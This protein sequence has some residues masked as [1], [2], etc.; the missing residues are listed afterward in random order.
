M[1]PAIDFRHGVFLSNISNHRSIAFNSLK[2][3]QQNSWFQPGYRTVYKKRRCSVVLYSTPVRKLVGQEAE[4]SLVEKWIPNFPKQELFRKVVMVRFD[5]MILLQGMKEHQ[6][7]PANSF[8]TIKYLYEADAKVVLMSSWNENMSSRFTSESCPS[9]ESVAVFLSSMLELKVVLVNFVPGCVQLDK[10]ECKTPN[11]LLLENLSCF[12]GERANCSKFAK[13]LASG[14]DIIV[15]DAFSESHKVLASTVGVASFCYTCMAGFYFEEGLY[16]LKKIIKTSES[17][18]LAIVGGGNLVE[19]AAALKFLASTCDGLIFVGSMAFQILHVLGVPVPVKFVDLGALKAAVSIVEFAKSRN[20][21]LVLPKDVRCIKY[22][23]PEQMEIF[24][25]HSIPEGWQPVDIGPRSLEEMISFLLRCKYFQKVTWI[26]PLRFSSPKQDE[27]G[28]FKLAEAL[29]TLSGC[30]VTFVGQT[31]FEELMGKS[32]SFPNVN[33]LKSSA[34]VWKVLNGRKLPGLMALDRVYPF[35]VD[36]NV[37]YGDP[38]RPLV[39]DVGSG[40]GLFLFGMASRRKEM[41]FLGLEMNTKLVDRCLNDVHRLGIQNVHFISTNATSTF[42]SIVS[43]YTGEL[44]LVSIQCPNPDFNK[45]ENRWRMLQMSLVKAIAD[46]LML[47]GKSGL[48]KNLVGLAQ[49]KEYPKI[50]Q[51]KS[52]QKKDPNKNMGNNPR[53]VLDPKVG[54]RPNTYEHLEA[55]D[56][57]QICNSIGFRPRV[58]RSMHLFTT[59]GTF[60]IR[61]MAIKNATMQ[62]LHL[63]HLEFEAVA[64][65][66][67]DLTASWRKTHGGGGSFPVVV[68]TKSIHVYKL[69]DVLR[70]LTEVREA[71]QVTFSSL[72]SEIETMFFTSYELDGVDGVRFN[73]NVLVPSLDTHIHTNQHSPEL[74]FINA[75]GVNFSPEGSFEVSNRIPQ[76]A[77]HGS[78]VVFVGTI[79]IEFHEIG[80]SVFL[81]S[82]IEAVAVRMKNEFIE[83]GDGKLVVAEHTDDVAINEIGWLEKNPFGVPSDWEKHVL[84]RGDPMY[85]LLLSKVESNRQK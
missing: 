50:V 7:L 64:I 12:K 68:Q 31:E 62:T 21:P 20:I 46:L 74:G 48:L 73:K 6:P 22:L 13:E 78:T 25:V 84:D 4:L 24:S 77:S 47:G 32:N 8:S 14:V 9:T 43:S 11:I 82:D 45:P 53:K 10:Q 55:P 18:Y 52:K 26:G 27:G 30:D 1:N 59:N 79:N 56:P 76:N 35:L 83:Y 57:I 66:R 40:N 37:A 33:I 65:P 38:M 71:L 29:G 54:Q 75:I 5:P 51:Q 60:Q 17:P 63:L 34:V 70:D 36:W 80:I 15:N 39:V 85:R 61:A 3:T 49:G 28:T 16:K 44:V 72:I 2:I 41:N 42:R 19:K 58:H 81:Q 67:Q 69:L 23:I